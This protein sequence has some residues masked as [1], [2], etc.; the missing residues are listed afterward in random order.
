[1]SIWSEDTFFERRRPV[2]PASPSLDI[3]RI[4]RRP[5]AYLLRR[6]RS[7]GFPFGDVAMVSQAQDGVLLCTCLCWSDGECEHT[8]AVAGWMAAQ[9]DKGV[10]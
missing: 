5:A 4:A 7:E 10:R 3:Q 1:M 9:Q 6:G 8:R 2:Q